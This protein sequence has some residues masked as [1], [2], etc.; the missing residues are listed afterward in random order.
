MYNL[1]VY[2]YIYIGYT[3]VYIYI[4]ISFSLEPSWMELDRWPF[5][6]F[7]IPLT[8]PEESEKKVCIYKYK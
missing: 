6:P 5:Q 7:T 2:I 8:L 1:C 4:Y 3:C